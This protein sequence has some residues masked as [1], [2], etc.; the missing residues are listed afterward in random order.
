MTRRLSIAGPCL[1]AVAALGCVAC[2]VPVAQREVLLGNEAFGRG[3]Y[4]EATVHYLAAKREGP[5]QQEWIDYDL[6]NVYHSLGETAVAMECWDAAARSQ[7]RS[8]LFKVQSNRGVALYEAGRF[9][10]AY[11][12]FRAAIELSPGD[13]DAKL[14]LELTQK[15][16]QAAASAD[17]LS[18]VAGAAT[19]TAAT[20]TAASSTAASS[21]AAGG[22]DAARLLEYVRRKEGT[23]WMPAS[24][25]AEPDRSDDW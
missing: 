6:G 5:Q 20:S 21:T 16:L 3:D 14:N 22:T 2:V 17:E 25:S 9:A 10:D 1:L 24:P 18:L 19:S 7:D 13:P 11:R 12:A 8:L 4:Q 23:L 15:K